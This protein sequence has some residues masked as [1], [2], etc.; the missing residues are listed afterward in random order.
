MTLPKWSEA[1]AGYI[2]GVLSFAA[3]AYLYWRSQ[4]PPPTGE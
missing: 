3:L 1:Y 4:M 2:V